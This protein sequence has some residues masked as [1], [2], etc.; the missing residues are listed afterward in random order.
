MSLL[1]TD[2]TKVIRLS[3]K[4]VKLPTPEL[5]VNPVTYNQIERTLIKEEI[6]YSKLVNTTPLI[7]ELVTK[8]NLVSETTGDN[9][10]KVNIPHPLDYI[11]EVE[12]N[13]LINLAQSLLSTDRVYTQ[14]EIREQIKKFLLDRETGLKLCPKYVSFK[15]KKGFN[16]MLQAGAIKIILGGRYCLTGSTLF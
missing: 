6:I 8:L 2:I 12:K 13:K 1:S 10:N 4:E 5:R 3:L 7:E 15:A 16:L 11:D 9:I 14:K